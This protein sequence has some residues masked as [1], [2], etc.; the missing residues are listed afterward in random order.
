MNKKAGWKELQM[1]AL[2]VLTAG[3]EKC[4]SRSFL[5]LMVENYGDKSRWIT[6]HIGDTEAIKK[7]V[8]KL[9]ERIEKEGKME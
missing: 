8:I 3:N 7:A 4:Q 6:A 1:L 5:V 2:K 9:A